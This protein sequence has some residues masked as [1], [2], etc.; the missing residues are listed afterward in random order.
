MLRNNYKIAVLLAT[1][2]GGKYIREQLDSLF[3]QSCK[4]FHLYVR[5]DGSSD[6]TMKIVGQFREMYPDRVT[7][8]KDS[9]KHRGAAKSF[10]Y[11]LENV[12]S[13]YYMFCDQDD[14][15]LPEKIEKTFARMKEAEGTAPV[16]V[17]TDLRVVDE[18]LSPIKESFNED[19]K[20][21]VF[22]KHPELI[23]V[24]HVVT[25]CTMMF[26]RAA[27][28]V[29]LP[30]SPRATMHDEWV[31]LCVHFKGGVISILDDATILY[32]QHTSN[33]LGA[34]QARKGFFARAIARAG[35]KQ[36]FQVAKLLHKDFGLSYLK[37]LM[38][39][40]L[41]SWF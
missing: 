32:R 7:I 19:L 2:N 9:Q 41:Y 17:A 26:N 20:I 6:D 4:Q 28:E 36:F 18:Q 11:L 34:E 31:A 27:K 23:C 15:W 14:I 24:R 21:D 13:E 29:S 1:Y 35:Q 8:L 16:L 40:I 3:Q 39:K 25:G 22:R 10:M 38:Y 5:D 12:D 37:F 30:M 33:T